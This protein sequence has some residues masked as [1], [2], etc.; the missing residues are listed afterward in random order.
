[1]G[2]SQERRERGR[3]G[4]SVMV[5]VSILVVMWLKGNCGELARFKLLALII[6]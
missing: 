1:M 2:K 5:M 6:D 4:N 3:D